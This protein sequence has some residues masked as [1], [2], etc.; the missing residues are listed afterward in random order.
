[1]SKFRKAAATQYGSNPRRSWLHFHSAGQRREDTSHLS[2]HSMLCAVSGCISHR[3]GELSSCP[4]VPHYADAVCSYGGSDIIHSPI[5]AEAI[6]NAVAKLSPYQEKEGE[7]HGSYARKASE[8]NVRISRNLGLRRRRSLVTTGIR[9]PVVC[10]LI[11]SIA[12]ERSR[13]QLDH[14]RRRLAACFSFRDHLYLAATRPRAFCRSGRNLLCNLR[15]N[16]HCLSPLRHAHE[17][18]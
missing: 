16:V 4:P 18:R 17:R 14:W 3:S 5:L 12:S 7:A 11:L 6:E 1:M 2:S 10:S 9:A 15:G 13:V 8:G